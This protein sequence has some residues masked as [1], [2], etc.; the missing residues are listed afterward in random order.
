MEPLDSFPLW[1]VAGMLYIRV[2]YY[3][4]EQCLS[5]SPTI[6]ERGKKSTA[7]YQLHQDNNGDTLWSACLLTLLVEPVQLHI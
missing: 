3:H 5:L 6:Q 1:L 7:T 4:Q 2:L